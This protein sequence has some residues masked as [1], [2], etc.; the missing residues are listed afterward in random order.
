MPSNLNRRVAR[1]ENEGSG[2]ERILVAVQF[3]GDSQ[4]DAIERAGIEPTGD[5]LVVL[6]RR[7]S[8]PTEGE[9]ECRET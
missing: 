4:Q 9:T 6:I 7:F 1:L 5:D 2:K 8:T 3:P